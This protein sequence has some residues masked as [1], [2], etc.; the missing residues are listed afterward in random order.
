MV[1]KVASLPMLRALSL[2]LVVAAA[3]ATAWAADAP[4]VAACS[5]AS[6][7]GRP[8]YSE[9]GAGLQL[10]PGCQIEPTWRGRIS[11]SD[12]EIWVVDCNGETRT[13]LLRRSTVEMLAANQARL[14]F[15]VTDERRWPGETAGDTAS[16]QCV[17]R[18]APDAGF[19][20]VGAKWRP[21]GAELRLTSATTVLRADPVTQKFVPA[22][23]AQVDC[24]RHPE[25]EAMM[26]RLQ[27]R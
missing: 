9:P 20:V 16:V 4:P 1:A 15:L 6:Y 18:S 27:Q 22:T 24:A 21:A 12:F 13:W 19:V 5:A 23:L 8:I 7:L 2:C 14:R 11:N 26:R 17:G 10:P 25:R 3:A